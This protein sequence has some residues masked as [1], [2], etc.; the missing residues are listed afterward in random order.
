MSDKETSAVPV[1]EQS[2]GSP[3]PAKE[4]S[5]APAAAQEKAAEKEAPAAS[6]AAPA[7][8]PKTNG[9]HAAEDPKTNGNGNGDGD[10]AAESTDAAPAASAPAPAAAASAPESKGQTRT[11]SRTKLGSPAAKP[12]PKKAAPKTAKPRVSGA[13]A[14]GSKKAAPAAEKNFKIGDI[15]LA[16]LKGYPA[17][18]ARIADPDTLPRKVAAQRPNKNPMIFCVQYFPVGDYSWLNQRDLTSLTPSDISSYLESGHRKAT[19]GLRE[20]YQTAQDPTEWDEGQAQIVQ[21]EQE[22]EEEVDELADEDEGEEAAVT[23]GKRKKAAATG[24]KEGSKKKAKTEKKNDE[25]A[26]KSKKAAKPKAAKSKAAPESKPAVENQAADDDDPLSND[27]ECRKVKDWRHKLQRAFLGKA[28]PEADEMP[29]YDQLFKDIE[30]YKGMTTD[31]LTYS[32]IGKVMKKIAAI[33]TIP[34][35]DELKITTRAE[36]LMKDWQLV[37]DKDLGAKNGDTKAN[38][39]DVDA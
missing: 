25:T 5:P 6:E 22:G 9:D 31:A 19:G 26:D 21:R 2:A 20:A 28:L 18:P 7:E 33:S 4:A 15:V 17:W 27:P 1:E 14:G 32:K 11:S 13:A 10:H 38:G 3:A 23:G 30:A 12:A 36:K 37:I 29:G 16:R 39:M 35:D 8:E 24:G 34:K